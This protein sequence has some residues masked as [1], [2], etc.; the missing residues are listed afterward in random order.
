MC[1]TC[2]LHSPRAA[3]AAPMS[4]DRSPRAA[5]ASGGGSPREYSGRLAAISPS[6]RSLLFRYTEPPSTINSGSYALATLAMPA[7]AILENSR[8]TSE[9]MGSPSLANLNMVAASIE[10][11]DRSISLRRLATSPRSRSSRRA[12]LGSPAP[13][14]YASQCPRPPQPHLSSLL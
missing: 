12:S 6:R 7:A 2:G 14:Q 3:A 1:R 11:D 4:G 9:A 8:T 10:P 5:G 13:E